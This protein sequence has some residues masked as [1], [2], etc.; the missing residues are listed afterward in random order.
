MNDQCVPDANSQNNSMDE[1]II[2]EKIQKIPQP[3][4][5]EDGDG[6]TSHAK[7]KSDPEIRLEHVIQ[8]LPPGS[9]VRHRQIGAGGFGKVYEGTYRN[10]RVAIKELHVTTSVQETEKAIRGELKQY[11]R[12]RHC[13]FVNYPI[14][15]H[16]IDDTISLVMEFADNGD[17]GQY[18]RRPGGGLKDWCTK[19]RI[20]MD[21]AYALHEMHKNRIV[22]GDLKAE[23]VLLDRYLT[24]KLC[25]FDSSGS[26][27]SIEGGAILSCTPRYVAPERL[28]EQN[29]TAEELAI[30]DIYGFGIIMLQVATDGKDPF[31]EFR[32]PLDV[33]I[34][35]LNGNTVEI[36]EH[37]PPIFKK[38]IRESLSEAGERPS[39]SSIVLELNEYLAVASTP[40]SQSLPN[41]N[42]DY[43]DGLYHYKRRNWKKA[44]EYFE[45]AAERDYHVSSYRMLGLCERN[46][47]E[48]ATKAFRWFEKSTKA[49]DIEGFFDF[50]FCY[51]WGYGTE[52]NFEQ[53]L[54]HYGIAARAG[55]IRSLERLYRAVVD[56]RNEEARKW[57]CGRI[58]NS[59]AGFFEMMKAASEQKNSRAAYVLAKWYDSLP[60][61]TNSGKEQAVEW[62]MKSAEGG[63][64]LA[65]E[66]LVEFY[67]DGSCNFQQR[68]KCY[69]F[70]KSLATVGHTNSIEILC[71]KAA[72]KQYNYDSDVDEN[73]DP[74]LR[75]LHDSIIQQTSTKMLEEIQRIAIE[76]NCNVQY[77]LA[78]LYHLK[79]I[80]TKDPTSAFHWYALSAR[81]GCVKSLRM[82]GYIVR[83]SLKDE[84][85]AFRYF[86]WAAKCGDAIA[87]FEVGEYC[88]T[89]SRTIENENE[90]LQWFKLS[91]DK[92]YSKAVARLCEIASREWGDWKNKHGFRAG[93]FK[94]IYKN[95]R[96]GDLALNKL[97]IG[98][99]RVAEAENPYA[100]C[101][102]GKLLEFGR[103]PSRKQEEHGMHLQWYRR[104]GNHGHLQAQLHMGEVYIRKSDYNSA[105]AWYIMAARIGAAG[106]AGGVKAQYMAGMC[107][108]W[109][110]GTKINYEE[111][112][113]WYKKSAADGYGDAIQ[114][115]KTHFHDLYRNGH[116]TR[117]DGWTAE[118]FKEA[119]KW[120]DIACDC[121]EGVRETIKRLMGGQNEE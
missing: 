90:A 12:L 113:Y 85:Q 116:Q 42:K 31:A 52:M 14:G 96:K 43:D 120:L 8:T 38:I 44:I 58:S 94:W 15:L 89:A 100:E 84:I 57:I 62:M 121:P 13:S 50:A 68:V 59:D 101:V 19:T 114:R 64:A 37:I 67:R 23:N 86:T 61:A 29:L 98:I 9:V 80:P 54:E 110:W 108:E 21:I 2:V 24:P 103:I 105:F 99:K 48:D 106:G 79:A 95:I 6:N 7:Q 46:I 18:L 117:F 10:A 39:L 69:D 34:D 1:L 115:L 70:V 75:W 32:D 66:E 40:P 88:W 92:G 74:T 16:R 27:T 71:E 65:H 47:G 55:N 22:H 20:C 53:A 5:S 102:L 72:Y 104:A 41:R 76:G 33:V 91:A 82:L 119:R 63:N 112:L 97:F 51:E 81:G 17:L 83:D 111:A 3:M 77:V 56:E 36:P 30:A 45:K 107:F 35:K 4:H 87:Q 26:F 73:S 11:Y 25:D 49:G 93:T 78:K 118:D 60:N 109:G 28:R